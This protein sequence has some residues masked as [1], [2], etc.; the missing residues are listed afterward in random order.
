M[1]PSYLNINENLSP[2]KKEKFLFLGNTY[3]SIQGEKGLSSIYI[4]RVQKK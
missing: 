3:G 2:E 1:V 4:Q